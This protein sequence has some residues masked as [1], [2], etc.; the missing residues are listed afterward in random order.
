MDRKYLTFMVLSSSTEAPSMFKIRQIWLKL[1]AAGSSCVLIA[2]IIIF[3]RYFALRQESAELLHLKGSYISQKKEIE[4]LTTIVSDMSDDLS[5]LREYAGKLRAVTGLHNDDIVAAF[6]PGGLGG[7]DEGA[8]GSTQQWDTESPALRKLRG[9]ILNLQNLAAL[10]IHDF[11]E[12]L[13]AVV[14]KSNI[15]A[16]T[17]SIWPTQGWLSSKYGKRISPFTGYTVMHKGIDIANKK[18]TPVIAP[19]DGVVKKVGKDR[20][21]GKMLRITHGNGI[22]T[23]YA[24]LSKAVVKKGKQVKRGDIIG[25]MGNTGRSTASHLHYSVYKNGKPDNPLKYI[26]DE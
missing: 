20:Y 13:E 3:S 21:L 23:L 11:E 12:I 14:D 9:D 25:Y 24:H 7:E 2:V 5:N 17:P 15:L 19:A 6:P 1:L 26:I 18:G 22:E 4:E 10:Q 8:F 16:L